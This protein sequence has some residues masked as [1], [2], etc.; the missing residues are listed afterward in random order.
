MSRAQQLQFDR[1]SQSTRATADNE[2]SV[3]FQD[4]VVAARQTDLSLVSVVHW[5]RGVSLPMPGS[6]C[7]A[8]IHTIR[9]RLLWH[10]VHAI[11]GL[12][13]NLG[14][15]ALR[16]PVLRLL[17]TACQS[18][19]ERRVEVVEGSWLEVC[20][21]VGVQRRLQCHRNAR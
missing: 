10:M 12:L 1:S 3:L 16:F 19:L 13:I 7:R 5:A 8:S 20:Q 11:T 18:P 4:T 14:K 15:D 17:V 6:G 21:S 2:A 9:R